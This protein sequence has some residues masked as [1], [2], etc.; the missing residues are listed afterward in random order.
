MKTDI[1]VLEEELIVHQ[2]LVKQ[3]E[4]QNDILKKEKETQ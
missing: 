4:K 3:I 2:E 1:Q